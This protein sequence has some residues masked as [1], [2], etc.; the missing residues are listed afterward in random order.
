VVVQ[1][2]PQFVVHVFFD[3]QSYVALFGAEDVPPS[4]V[5]PPSLVLVPLAPPMLHVPPD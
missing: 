4:A 5:A 3:P 2:V 1:P